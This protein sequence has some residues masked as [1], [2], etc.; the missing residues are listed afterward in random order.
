MGK[1]RHD[2][3]H[4]GSSRG[5]DVMHGNNQSGPVPL[6]PKERRWKATRSH[7]LRSRR[8][9]GLNGGANK[10]NRFEGMRVRRRT[11]S[12]WRAAPDRFQPT[13]APGSTDTAARRPYRNVCS[14]PHP[15]NLL[16]IRARHG[17]T[18]NRDRRSNAISFNFG[19][20]LISSSVTGWASGFLRR[21]IHRAP[22][23]FVRG[24]VRDR[25]RES[26]GD[27]DDRF[28]GHAVIKKDAVA[29]A[30]RA[31]IIPRGVIPDAGPCRLAIRDE[32]RPTNR[33]TVP[34]SRARI[35]SRPNF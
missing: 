20:R 18:D 24:R 14:A 27:P 26:L 4:R 12:P 16:E 22:I 17:C 15:K 35:V 6:P 33:P 9:F 3:F 7:W 23:A 19:F 28:L 1:L 5:R 21:Q 31:Q 34:V 2:F 8:I 32:I 29:F 30:H 25:L 13:A 10:P 11:N